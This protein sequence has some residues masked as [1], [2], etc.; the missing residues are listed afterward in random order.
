[1]LEKHPPA[2]TPE[3]WQRREVDR[4]PRA[5]TDREG[6]LKVHG[7]GTSVII[8]DELRHPLAALCLEGREFGFTADDLALVRSRIEPRMADAKEP[9]PDSP[10]WPHWNTQ[11]RWRALANRIAALLPA[12]P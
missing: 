12:S 2:L 6:V 5:I 8:P 11:R 4:P 9:A 10:A 1:M 3:E 7:I